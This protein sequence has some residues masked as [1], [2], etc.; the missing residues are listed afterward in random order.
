MDIVQIL[1]NGG[2]RMSSVGVI[3]RHSNVK[4]WKSLI[5]RFSNPILSLLSNLNQWG[6]EEN[7]RKR[8]GHVLEGVGETD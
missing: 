1:N 2:S 7:E 8:M 4:I 6:N 3:K 5:I